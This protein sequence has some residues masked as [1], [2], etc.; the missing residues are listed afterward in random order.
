MMRFG[1]LAVAALALAACALPPAVADTASLTPPASLTTTATRS[2]TDAGTPS[3]TA[4]PALTPSPTPSAVSP[5][6]APTETPIPLHLCPPLGGYTFAELPLIE[7]QPFI[8][9]R[10]GK[11]DGHH[12]VDFAH[13]QYKDRASLEGA[14]VQSVL[15]GVVAASIADKY[16]YGNLVIVET[17]FTQLPEALIEAFQLQAGHS[18]YHLYAHLK[19]PSPVVLG[20][21]VACGEVVGLVGSSGASGNPHLH[22]ETR[23]GPAG[24]TFASMEY[25]KTTSTAE[26][27]T[28]YERWRFL[29]EFV[30]W[31]PWEL[32]RF[33]E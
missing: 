25:Y 12:G 4:L 28:N 21:A 3:P 33:G 19:E 32:L 17:P 9:P 8:P 24:L 6:A 23:T 30:L 29:G 10:P 1:W 5:L 7:S 26:E 13:W 14:P 16:P 15:A 22:F 18:L 11:D 27:R 31:N 20:Q 2:L